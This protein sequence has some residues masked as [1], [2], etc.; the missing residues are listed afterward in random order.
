MRFLADQDVYEPTVKRLVVLGHDV[1]EPG[2]RQIG[3]HCALLA[4]HGRS[5]HVTA[6]RLPKSKV[7]F[8]AKFF[9]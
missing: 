4:S 8:G 3:I 2:G 6:R 7:R 1:L 5:S 9:I